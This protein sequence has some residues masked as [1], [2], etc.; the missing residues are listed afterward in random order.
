MLVLWTGPRNTWINKTTYKP[1]L[2][3]TEFSS[4]KCNTWNKYVLFVNLNNV[5][6][7]HQMVVC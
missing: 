1:E 6:T 5:A 4:F 2:N 3:P 7:H